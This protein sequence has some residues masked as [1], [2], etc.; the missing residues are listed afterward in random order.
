MMNEK[1]EDLKM[2]QLRKCMLVVAIMVLGV[3]SLLLSGCQSNAYDGTYVCKISVELFPA[4]EVNS[5]VVVEGEFALELAGKTW[6]G[7][8]VGGDFKFFDII[9]EGKFTVDG[10]KITFTWK[11]PI[12]GEGSIFKTGTIKDGVITLRMSPTDEE[13]F[14]FILQT[15]E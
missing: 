14:K 11:H 10:E 8:D 1:M 12:Q 3:F 13:E 2:K 9:T 7:T 5:A 6:K 15:E 4:D